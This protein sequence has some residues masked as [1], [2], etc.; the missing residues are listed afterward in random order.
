MEQQNGVHQNNGFSATH[1]PPITTQ[2]DNLLMA[3]TDEPSVRYVS[4]DHI[5]VI[6]QMYASVWG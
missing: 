6:F 2:N 5:A 4:D 1:K 3:K